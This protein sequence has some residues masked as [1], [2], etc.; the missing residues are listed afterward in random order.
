[1]ERWYCRFVNIIRLLWF[2]QM[3][4]VNITIFLLLVRSYAYGCWRCWFCLLAWWCF[5]MQ[6]IF[7]C[8]DW[9]YWTSSFN[10]EHLLT[11]LIA[12]IG[13]QLCMNFYCMHITVFTSAIPEVLSPTC[14]FIYGWCEYNYP[15][16]EN[17]LLLR[18]SH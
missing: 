14:W 18:V 13:C 5:I 15:H 9:L 10:I 4:I 17:L 12:A 6:P 8:S 16:G 7:S 2:D 11:F 1:M 3:G